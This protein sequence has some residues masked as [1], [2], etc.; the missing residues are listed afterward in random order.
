M[1][2]E[3]MECT[4]R[5]YRFSRTEGFSEIRTEISRLKMLS[6]KYTGSGEIN[7]KE[8]T[9]ILNTLIYLNET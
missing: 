7:A 5:A 2:T 4:T 3:S 9:E 6:T 8:S 1:R